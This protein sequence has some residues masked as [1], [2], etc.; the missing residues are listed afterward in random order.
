MKTYIVDSFTNEAFKGNPAGVCIV[1]QAI[2]SNQNP[3]VLTERRDHAQLLNQLLVDKGFDALL[4][5]GAMKAKDR[6]NMSKRLDNSQVIIATG[7][8]IGEGFDLP[9]LDALFLAMP[10]AWKGT[11]SQ[12]A[13]RIHR[14]YEGK[15]EVTI[16]DYVDTNLPMLARMF[17]KREK[18]YK[19]MGYTIRV[20]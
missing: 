13:G 5:I 8:F 3:L 1:E 7:K 15:Q 18:G 6:V 17:K 16:F 10:I 2:D 14:E 20:L 11:L 4:L 9:K 19:N 12:Y